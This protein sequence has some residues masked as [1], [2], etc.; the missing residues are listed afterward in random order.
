MPTGVQ[1]GD[2]TT[3]RVNIAS[4]LEDKEYFLVNLSATPEEQVEIAADATKFPFV[5]VEGVD[6]SSTAGIGTIATG[7]RV[8]V[9]CGG[10]VNPG[11]KLTSDGDGKA[12]ATT[13]DTDHYGLIALE[14]GASNDVIEALVAFG[15]VSA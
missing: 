6:G 10:A 2:M 11:D 3:R 4:N 9:K 8:K 15:T 5:L 12:V 14:I 7:G 1:F 13:T